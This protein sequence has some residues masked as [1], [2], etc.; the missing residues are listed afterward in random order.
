[1]G[2]FETGPIRSGFTM[3]GARGLGVNLPES[4]GEVF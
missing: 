2:F 3:I 1:V 4:A